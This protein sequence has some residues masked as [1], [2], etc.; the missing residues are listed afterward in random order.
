MNAERGKPRIVCMQ[1]PAHIERFRQILESFAEVEYA[2][3]N[4]SELLKHI[5]DYDG[6]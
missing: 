5:K 2:D 3:W 4:A 1:V 6:M